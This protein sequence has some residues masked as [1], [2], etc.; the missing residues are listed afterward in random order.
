MT[1]F[2]RRQFTT[3]LAALTGLAV[4]GVGQ[5]AQAS[6]ATP[7]TAA[8]TGL[9]IS[10]GKLVEANG[11]NFILRGVSAAHVWYPDK[12]AQ[13]LIDIKALGANSVRIVLST[14]ARWTQSTASDVTNVINLCKQN[15]LIAI[16]EA[17]DTTGYGDDGAAITLSQAADYWV[18]IKSALQGQEN[19][20][21]LNIGNEP[22]GNN[23]TSIWTSSTQGAIQKIRNAGIQQTLMVDAPNWGQDWQFVMRDNARTV[24][25]ADSQGN[26]LF[27]IHM[28]GVYDTAAEI[29][30][31]LNA[32]TSAG[33][34]IAIGE[35]G[36][37]HTDGN[38]DEDTI[39][40]TAQQQGIGYMGWSWS[41]NSSDVAY[42]DMV[43]NFNGQSLTT[44]G[45]RIFHGANGISS[46]AKQATIYN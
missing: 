32:F 37:Q 12:T 16:L 10:G 38:P 45:E 27:S 35:F 8:A 34:P 18:G 4:T 46:T 28:Y 30:S 31:Y 42:L 29:A 39:M 44:W 43:N 26:T 15:K 2:T 14:G 33:L 40:S 11:S 5:T 13:S 23:N 3:G 41:G 17:H 1:S 22:I 9:H 25:S 6:V 7:A 36:N 24:A 19:Y 21:I 20:T